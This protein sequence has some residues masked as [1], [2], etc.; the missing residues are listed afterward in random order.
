MFKYKSCCWQSCFW[1]ESAAVRVRSGLYNM[2]LPVTWRSTSGLPGRRQT[3]VVKI[4]N[5]FIICNLFYGAT[6]GANVVHNYMNGN[7]TYHNR[8]WNRMYICNQISMNQYHF[9]LIFSLINVSLSDKA[10]AQVSIWLWNTDHVRDLILI[11]EQY[12]VLNRVVI[13]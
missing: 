12:Y 11:F 4:K 6:V 8:Q 3:Y 13:V 2:V 5:E 10:I 9:N 7:P 1:R